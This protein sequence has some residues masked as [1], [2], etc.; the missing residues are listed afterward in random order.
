M[1]FISTDRPEDVEATVGGDSLRHAQCVR[2]VHDAQRGS[3]GS[4]GN[5]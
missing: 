1:S 3:D 5:S 2:R 4:A